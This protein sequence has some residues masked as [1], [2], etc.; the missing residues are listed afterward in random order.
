MMD[1]TG[2]SLVPGEDEDLRGGRLNLSRQKLSELEPH[3]SWQQ[4]TS[5]DVS[6]NV[7][8]RRE[9]GECSAGTD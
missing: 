1:V 7:S 6:N 8:G 9:L 2:S 5:L 4:L 3:P